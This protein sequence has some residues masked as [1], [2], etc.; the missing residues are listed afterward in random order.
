MSATPQRTEITEFVMAHPL[1][2]A[3]SHIQPVQEWAQTKPRY[4]SIGGYAHADLVTA[5]GP[6][7]VG[8]RGPLADLDGDAHRRRYFQLW[9]DSRHTGYCRPIERA[10]RDLLGLE[11]VEENADAIGDAI[12]RLVGDDPLESYRHVLRDRANVRWLVKDSINVPKAATKEAY[13]PEFVCFNYRDDGLM[14]IRSRAEVLDWEARWNRSLHSVGDLVA[15]LNESISACLATGR[16]TSFKLGVAYQRR[17]AFG[18]PT[19]HEAETA[20]AR[21]MNVT[22]GPTV[23]GGPVERGVRSISRVGADALR[24]LQDYLVHQYLRRIE[25]EGKPL[26]VHTGYLAGNYGV[27]NHIRAMDLVPLLI[28]YP[29]VRFDLFHAGWPYTEQH[30]VLG[31][32]FP[33]VWLNLCWMWAMNP[34]T[35]GRALD[36]WLACVPHGKIF[37]YGGDT[38]SPVCEYGYAQQA[39]AGIARVLERKVR[40]GE[41]TVDDAKAVATA[42]M[43][44][45]GCRFHGLEP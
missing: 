5:A 8:H 11:Y 18:E 32:E 34:V 45:N 23:D 13:P 40:R 4:D 10:C 44:E 39:R 9:C 20:F 19:L 24:P 29:R 15:G 7:G 30:A 38:G 26:Q 43:L 22:V 41:T 16:V 35:A 28:R 3:H 2:G 37:A 14:C 33:N 36:S 27:L 6:L 25:A 12:G 21:L 1:F 17:L 31:K 42:V